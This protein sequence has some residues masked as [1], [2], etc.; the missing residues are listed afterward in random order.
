M[1]D[2][3]ESMGFPYEVDSPP[4]RIRYI[5]TAGEKQE[6]VCDNWR[7][8]RDMGIGIRAAGGQVLVMEQLRRES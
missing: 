1:P 5:N 8:A 2:V 4:V 6:A 3:L 7:D